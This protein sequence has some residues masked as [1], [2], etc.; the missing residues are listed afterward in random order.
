MRRAFGLTA[1]LI[2]FAAMMVAVAQP[3][4]QVWLLMA[5]FVV[6]LFGIMVGIADPLADHP[7][8]PPG[9]PPPPIDGVGDIGRPPRGR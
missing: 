7:D 8:E 2:G 6:L 4:V 5:G 1:A 3:T 9:P